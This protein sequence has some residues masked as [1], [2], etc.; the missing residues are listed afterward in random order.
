[1]ANLSN[2]L[3]TA[4]ANTIF[5]GNAWTRPSTVYFALFSETP[6][7]D[8]R[9]ELPIGVNGYQRVSVDNN[10][11]TWGA[12]AAEG[13][14][15]RTTQIEIAFPQNITANWGNVLGVGIYDAP[16]GGNL[17]VWAALS[18]PKT[19]NVNDSA[20]FAVGSFTFSID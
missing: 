8:S 12:S 5:G 6:T 14:N 13:T 4:I 10:A 11:A 2:Y 16:T 20:K 18:T 19:I 15:S 3:E 7:D 17:L 9:V 1:M